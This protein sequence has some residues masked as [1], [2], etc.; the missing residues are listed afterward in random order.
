MATPKAE[1]TI[2]DV[3]IYDILQQKIASL[4]NSNII[5]GT[6]SF[7]FSDM[8]ATLSNNYGGSTSGLA[9]DSFSRGGQV[10]TASVIVNYAVD[11]SKKYS[12]IR[13]VTVV[14][15]VTASGGPAT[16]SSSRTGKTHLINSFSDDFSSPNSVNISS[17][18]SISSTNLINY[19]DSCRN[20]YIRL[21]DL[22]VSGSFS[23][24]HNSCHQSCHNNRGRR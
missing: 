19:I 12:R 18:K 20:E 23:V 15:N 5:Y 22:T 24:C 17:E 14:R 1:N 9:Q 8:P 4:A 11:I 2:D 21:R 16:S 10:I 13:N 3:D 6:N 7:H